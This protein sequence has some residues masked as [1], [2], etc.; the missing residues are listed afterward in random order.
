MLIIMEVMHEQY[1]IAATR[2]ATDCANT[3]TS[4]LAGMTRSVR[5]EGSEAAGS[6]RFV[7]LWR[8]G[9]R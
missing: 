7:K 1:G 5:G 2:L 9:G 8:A 4:R 6:G 3:I